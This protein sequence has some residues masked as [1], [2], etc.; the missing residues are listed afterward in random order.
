MRLRMHKHIV[1]H[2]G[3]FQCEQKNSLKRNFSE[4]SQVMKKTLSLLI[5]AS[6]QSTVIFLH[7]TIKPRLGQ[8][9]YPNWHFLAEA[10]PL[11]LIRKQSGKL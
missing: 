5:D 7:M 10:A 2:N 1:F 3:H 9:I 11:K 6:T 8:K 4:I